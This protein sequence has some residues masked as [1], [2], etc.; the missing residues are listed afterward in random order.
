LLPAIIGLLLVALAPLHAQIA[1]PTVGP[2]TVLTPLQKLDKRRKEIAAFFEGPVVFLKIDFTKEEWENLHRDNRRYAECTMLLTTQAGQKKLFKNVALKLKGSAGSFRGPDDKPGVT[3]SLK[4]FKGGDRFFGMD[5]F[6][7]NNCAQDGTFFH[8][9]IS[10]EVARAIGVP[11]SRCTHALL[12]LQGKDFGLYVFKEAFTEEF[13]SHFFRDIDGPIYDG[14]FVSEISAEMEKDSGDEEKRD[15]IK[16]LIAACEEQNLQKR[17]ALLERILD[18]PSFIRYIATESVLSHWDGYNFNRN[19]YRVFFDRTTGKAH[20]FLHGMDQ[21]W[22]EGRDIRQGPVSMV[23]Q[24]VFSNPA[25]KSMYQ[26]TVAAIHEKILTTR[27]WEERIQQ[28]GERVKAALAKRSP[29]EAEEFQGHINDMRNQ[30]RARVANIGRQLGQAPKPLAFD[31]KQIARLGGKGWRQEGSATF[32]ET[33]VDGAPTFY[34]KANGGDAAS[35]RRNVTLDPGKYRFS[36]MVRTWQ[37]EPT[38]G[39]SGEGVGIRISGGNRNGINSVK[40]SAGWQPIHFDFESTGGDVV[41]V[42][43]ARMSK[44]EAWF[45]TNA[46]TLTKLQ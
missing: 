24:A 45:Q 14:G 17:W 25:W 21:T 35:W 2:A 8:E 9:T 5:K 22:D 12:T 18:V 29:K 38:V 15:D 6:H 13:I 32:S 28:I 36:A 43:E 44:G 41:L 39:G 4:K 33:S 42:A 23:G 34:I 20:F 19:N 31:A 3:I 10:G 46:F 27:D 26:P 37:V 11:A 30:F 7:L 40:G 16:A 1:P